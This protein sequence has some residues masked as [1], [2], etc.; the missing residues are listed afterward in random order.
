MDLGLTGRTVLITG[1]NRG[2]G[3]VI[4]SQ[5]A[6]EGARVIMHAIDPA[7]SY[8]RVPGAFGVAGDITTAAGADAVASAALDC[9]GELDVLVNNYGAS[10]TASWAEGTAEDWQHIYAVNAVSVMH[11]AQRLLPTL[12]SSS[13]GRIVNLGTNGVDR[14]G[15]R[16]PH[17]YASK[18]ALVTM[19][20]SLAREAGPEVT[21]NLVS[22]GLIRTP[23]VEAAWLKRGREAGW[24]D[25]WEQI[26]PHVVQTSFPN[27]MG[28]VATREE[29]ADTV[30]YLASSRAGFLSGQNVRVDG[31][32]SGVA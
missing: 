29:V 16:N 19:S 14:P 3:W 17:Y 2:T 4:A 10:S 32:G 27:P 15:R 30:L 13:A 8:E 23:E 12:R 22:P 20:Q 18:A 5:F 11:L 26:E 21:V 9:T 25:T 28:R 7:A 24:G 31:G 6:A 1:S